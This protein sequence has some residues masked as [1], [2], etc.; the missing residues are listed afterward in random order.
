MY[1][2]CV[3]QNRELLRLQ[4][5]LCYPGSSPIYICF[6]LQVTVLELFA[7]FAV[8]YS[9]R[10]FLGW[11]TL[12][13]QAGQE[14]EKVDS[15]RVTSLPSQYISR[16]GVYGTHLTDLMISFGNTALVDT[17]GI[18]PED[19]RRIGKQ[20]ASHMEEVPK[21]FA[22]GECFTVDEK[23][24]LIHVSSPHI[25]KAGIFDIH[26]AVPHFALNKTIIR[27]VRQQS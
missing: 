26:G 15:T 16:F 14:V 23:R 5:L 21:V 19:L 8:P 3:D 25:R 2:Y 22:A 10:V 24:V 20:L 18:D 11:R 9:S 7:T 27:K 13:C 12:G 17:N 4:D 1:L 6:E